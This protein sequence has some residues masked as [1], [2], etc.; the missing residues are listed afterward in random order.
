MI[1]AL[2]GVQNVALN[3]VVFFAG[4]GAHATWLRLKARH[5]HQ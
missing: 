4:V 2:T 5:G 1:G 3:A